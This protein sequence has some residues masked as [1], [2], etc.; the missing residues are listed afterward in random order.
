[1]KEDD[2]LNPTTP[3][4]D[5][6]RP[7]PDANRVEHELHPPL[8]IPDIDHAAASQAKGH[9]PGLSGMRDR[10]SPLSQHID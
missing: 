8:F 1:M 4:S 2:E 9:Y 5:S 7:R 6:N 3:S 10:L